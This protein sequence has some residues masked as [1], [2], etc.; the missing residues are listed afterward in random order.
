MK[1]VS[2]TPAAHGS[3]TPAVRAA[4]VRK[5]DVASQGEAGSEARAP[6][7]ADEH[8]VSPRRLAALSRNTAHAPAGQP[9]R[10]KAD[11]AY[12][13]IRNAILDGTLAPGAALD[14]PADLQ[15]AEAFALSRHR[16]HRAAG[17]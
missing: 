11:E 9:R 4:S 17:L 1:Q 10:S 16:R 8:V 5:S 2:P 7:E 15:G 14:K 3:R 6:R 12:A 13:A